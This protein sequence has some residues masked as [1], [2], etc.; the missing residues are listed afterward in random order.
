MLELFDFYGNLLYISSKIYLNQY[1]K[2]EDDNINNNENN[3][4]DGNNDSNDNNNNSNSNNGNGDKND[5]NSFNIR[6]NKITNSPFQ[7]CNFSLEYHF[8]N[9]LLYVI[10]DRSSPISMII[11]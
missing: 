3:D 10:A 4:N 11:S 9:M 2:K 7:L 1:R 5:K 6:S 8:Y